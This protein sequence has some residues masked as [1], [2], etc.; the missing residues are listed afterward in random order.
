MATRPPV[1]RLSPRGQVTLPASVRAALGLEPGDVFTV[2]VVDGRVV[3]EPVEVVPVERYTDERVSE[4]LRAAEVTDE[5][6][7]DARRR[8]NVPRR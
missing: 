1:L 6:L 2:T 5:E 3:L 4:F 7:A 8:W